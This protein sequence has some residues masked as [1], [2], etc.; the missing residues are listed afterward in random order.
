[1]GLAQLRPYLIA[2]AIVVNTQAGS[3]LCF[4]E[5]VH[6]EAGDLPFSADNP[7][8]PFYPCVRVVL[9]EETI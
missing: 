5:H 1:M 7:N 6:L 3:F 9:P 4:G 8:G 2:F